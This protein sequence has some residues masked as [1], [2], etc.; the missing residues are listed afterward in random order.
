MAANSKQIKINTLAKDFNMKTKDVIDILAQAGIDKKTSGTIDT[1]EFS[2]FLS[3]ATTDHQVTNM[4]DY[5][6]GKAEL[7]IS[8]LFPACIWALSMD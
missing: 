2:V 1:D 3:R 8:W 4:S 6:S 5:L 7:H